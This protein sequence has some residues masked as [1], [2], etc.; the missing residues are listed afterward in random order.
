MK[1][2]KKEALLRKRLTQDQ[3]DYKKK[4]FQRKFFF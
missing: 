2:K 3:A 4:A 1:L